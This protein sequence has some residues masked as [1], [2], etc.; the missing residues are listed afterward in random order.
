M[1]CCKQSLS[2]LNSFCPCY[3]AAAAAPACVANWQATLTPLLTNPAL[4][5][6]STRQQQQSLAWLSGS[7]C[8]SSQNQAQVRQLFRA[9]ASTAA[10]IVHAP[11][12]ED[13]E[14][15]AIVCGQL[16]WMPV[17]PCL[18]ASVT[19]LAV[20]MLVAQTCFSTVCDMWCVYF[21]ALSN[22]LL[23]GALVLSCPDIAAVVPHQVYCEARQYLHCRPAVHRPASRWL[24]LC[25][26]PCSASPRSTK[27]WA[28]RP[29]QSICNSFPR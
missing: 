20:A 15:N 23:Q 2:L 21:N 26:A 7:T 25:H 4:G 28:Q 8:P 19:L 5:S 14:N 22:Y 27:L 12:R 16:C 11:A 13:A 17:L 3:V 10:L 24:T 6:C 9:S 1:C 18:A 29:S